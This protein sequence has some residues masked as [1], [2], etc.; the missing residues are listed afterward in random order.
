MGIFQVYRYVGMI[1]IPL[2]NYGRG[3][4][5]NSWKNLSMV[6]FN[7]ESEY[8]YWFFLSNWILAAGNGATTPDCRKNTDFDQSD[9]G[10]GSV[11]WVFLV[12]IDPLTSSWQP[13]T[14]I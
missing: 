5:Y 3:W 1:V 12:L 13:T 10:E 11:C 6:F 14:N 2:V 7:H 8:P 4:F 9:R